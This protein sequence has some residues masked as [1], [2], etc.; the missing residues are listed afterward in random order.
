[1][2]IVPSCRQR[3]TEMLLCAAAI[4]LLPA[5]GSFAQD[6]PAQLNPAQ[7]EAARLFQQINWTRGPA[8][9][10]IGSRA[11]IT[12]P[13]GFMITDRAGSQLWNQL[14]QNPPDGT[15]A[16][17]MPTSDDLSW[18]LCFEF[19]EVGYVKDDEKDEL[20]ADAILEAM[21]EGTEQSNQ[22]RRS[23]GWTA[24]HVAGWVYPP[25]YDETTNNLYWATRLTSD[26]GDEN[27]NY[28]TRLLGRRGVMQ[29]TLVC[30]VEAMPTVVPQVQE[31]LRTGFQF[32]SGEKYA[33]WRDGDKLATYGLTGLIT[34][35]AVVAAA[36]TGLL[37]RLGLV[38]AK[39]GK[40]IF[41][42]I[43]VILGGIYRLFGGG[44]AEE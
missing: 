5:A 18:F 31:M 43:A 6:D 33:E 10:P 21:Q 9:A 19:D 8:T 4:V 2:V 25:S 40:A 30:G 15:I 42:V 26:D 39:A 44:R 14:T 3:L 11:E 28:S 34:G 13:E 20:D 36:K 35:G 7:M 1:M 32:N 29:V 37:A 22:Y 16:T 17:L 24:I 23:Q 12:L 38:L 27:A 41:A